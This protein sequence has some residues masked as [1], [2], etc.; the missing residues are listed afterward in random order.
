MN[1]IFNRV[2]INCPIVIQKS[3]YF[4]MNAPLW[5]RNRIIWSY[6]R[7]NF[8][9]CPVIAAWLLSH[10]HPRSKINISSLL[11]SYPILKTHNWHEQTVI[12]QT[13][14]P[15]SMLDPWRASFA[16]A[17]S[18][19]PFTTHCAHVVSAELECRCALEFGNH[20]LG[21]SHRSAPVFNSM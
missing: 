12:T 7:R 20:Q 8:V 19:P 9:F 13:M 17:W 18:P 14:I 16:P 2:I 10:S 21:A 5:W 15:L 3:C 6:R 1:A 11:N 4:G